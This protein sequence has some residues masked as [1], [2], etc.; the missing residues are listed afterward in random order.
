MMPD[1]AW[2]E[3]VEAGWNVL[4]DADRE[5]IISI[6]LGPEVTATKQGEIYGN[7]HAGEMIAKILKKDG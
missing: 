5:K 7:G 4:V 2:I 1:T 6:A 3:L